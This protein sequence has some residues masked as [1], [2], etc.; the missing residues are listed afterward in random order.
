MPNGKIAHLVAKDG[1]LTATIAAN[2]GDPFIRLNL[3]PPLDASDVTGVLARMRWS[4]DASTAGG[5]QFFWFHPGHTSKGY[6]V[7]TPTIG[8]WSLST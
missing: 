3:T 4:V 5:K 8:R 7:T 1:V 2:I 6:E